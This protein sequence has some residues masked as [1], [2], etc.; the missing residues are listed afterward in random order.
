MIGAANEGAVR[1]TGGRRSSRTQITGENEQALSGKV[2]FRLLFRAAKRG[3]EAFDINAIATI[4][5]KKRAPPLM[6]FVDNFILAYLCLCYAIVA[7]TTDCQRHDRPISVGM[8]TNLRL[9]RTDILAC[10]QMCAS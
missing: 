8:R 10:A 7:S 6:L 3:G 9:Q 5:L 4:A 1:M 2:R